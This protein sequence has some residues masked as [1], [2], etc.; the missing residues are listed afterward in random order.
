M[1][2]ERQPWWTSPATV[3]NSAAN[4]IVFWLGLY[5]LVLAAAVWSGAMIAARDWVSFPEMIRDW[6]HGAVVSLS[7]GWGFLTYVL[8]F[9]FL[10][11]LQMESTGRWKLWI[12]LC[13][14]LLLAFDTW[15]FWQDAFETYQK[16]PSL[17]QYF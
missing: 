15:W 1:N 12:L 9:A 2:S 3:F 17:F 5:V 8:L 10:F 6:W 14:F 11:A 4:H 16:P 7:S 13:A